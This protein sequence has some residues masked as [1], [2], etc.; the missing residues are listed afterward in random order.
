MSACLRVSLVY[1]IY[2]Y[3][4][5]TIQPSCTRNIEINTTRMK[6]FHNKKRWRVVTIVAVAKRINEKK[7]LNLH[8]H[9]RLCTCHRHSHTRP[10]Y[11]RPQLREGYCPWTNAQ[12][13]FYDITDQFGSI[14]KKNLFP[15]SISSWNR[16]RHF[17]YAYT[18]QVLLPIF[19]YSFIPMLIYR[20]FTNFN[21]G[22]SRLWGHCQWLHASVY[23]MRP[24]ITHLPISMSACV[25]KW[26]NRS[27]L[28]YIYQH[29]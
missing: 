13:V 16:H 7:S 12:Q 23:A 18:I 28:I 8:W 9:V 3:H 5:H 27:I 29:A 15:I 22:E 10:E 6:K 24:Y 11:S 19:L 21:L 1:F 17:R 4:L 26:A 14:W 20:S 2:I 25:M